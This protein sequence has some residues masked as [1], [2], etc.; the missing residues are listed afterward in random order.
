MN[1]HFAFWLIVFVIG[2][3][4]II[5][6]SRQTYHSEPNVINADGL[7]IELVAPEPEPEPAQ[8]REPV[9]L[10]FTGVGTDLTK[11]F[12]LHD[13][14]VIIHTLYTWSNSSE[15]FIARLERL[16]GRSV[17]RGLLVNEMTSPLRPSSRVDVRRMLQVQSG[18]FVIQV[19]AD[20]GNQW[21]IGVFQ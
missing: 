4:L 11:S 18:E 20:R 1:K 8:K 15:N 12:Q 7:M 5:I 3:S 17:L 2:A 13:G 9:R 21:T 14:M 10:E 16:D 19:Q 6:A